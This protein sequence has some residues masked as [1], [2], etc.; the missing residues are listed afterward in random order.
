VD[1]VNSDDEEIPMR[2]MSWLVCVPFAVMAAACGRSGP[3]NTD[4]ALKTDLALAAQAQP[5]A[6][7][8]TISPTEA[9]LATQAQPQSLQ[10]VER[11]PVARTV[12]HRSSAP[13][14]SSS[15]SGSGSYEPA[16]APAP[17]PVHTVKHTTRDAAIGAGAGAVLGAITSR[18]KIK[19]G[20]IG[21]AVG[22]VLG[23]VLGNNVDVQKKVGW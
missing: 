17:P 14:R 1:I 19:G 3:S 2:R 13:R 15:S 22:G 6:A 11:A 20:L 4:D 10:A 5:A 7:Q 12:T 21:A 18:N 9:G 23:G 16:P 8:P